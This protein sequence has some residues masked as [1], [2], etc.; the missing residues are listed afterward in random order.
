MVPKLRKCFKKYARKLKC[1]KISLEECLEALN[2]N[3]VIVASLILK[4]DNT[5]ESF[6]KD[7][8][9]GIFSRQNNCGI[10]SYRYAVVIIGFSYPIG[11]TNLYF[12]IKNSWG[13]EFGDSGYFRVYE[14]ALDFSFFD[15][16][17]REGDLT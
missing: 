6:F 2:C 10:D 1:K 5:L 4:N 12:K 16:Y 15:V 3:R 8:P 13:P 11:S 17:Y 14:D 7:N 9:K